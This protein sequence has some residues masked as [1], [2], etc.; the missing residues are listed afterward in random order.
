M[1]VAGNLLCGIPW[2]IFQT[3]TTAY[4]AEICPTAMRGYLTTWVSM[5]WG[6]GSFLAAGILRAS[7]QLPD[8]WAWRMPYVLQWAWPAPLFI[9]GFLAPESPWHLVRTGNFEQ[10]AKV[11]KRLARK[12]HLSDLQVA[13]EI[14]LIKHTNEKE[15]EDAAHGSWLDCFKGVNLRRTEI[16][17]ATFAIQV[18]TGQ[19]ITG[20]ATTL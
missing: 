6:C 19:G 10:A 13:A 1:L 18:W 20:Y 17:C 15:K 14:A 3:L 7:L 2:G 4:A 11:L 12:G 8:D 16:A 9:V 5:C